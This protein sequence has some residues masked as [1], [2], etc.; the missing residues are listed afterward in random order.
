MLL[1]QEEINKVVL[2][3]ADVLSRKTS[4]KDRS[5]YPLIG[6]A[7]SITI[8]END[9]ENNSEIFANIKMDGTK[10]NALMIPAGGFRLKSS[11]ETAILE[12]DI[13]GHFRAKD[14]YVMKGDIVF[15]F[16]QTAIPPLIDDLINFSDIKKEDIDYYFF[17]QAN[18]F[19]LQKL[20]D[21][22]KVS[23]NKMP[24]N[25]VENFGNSSGASIPTA[26]A[27]NLDKKILTNKYKV[28]LC[29][30]GV[31][32]TW[33]SMLLDMGKLNICEMIDYK[34]EIE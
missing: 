25:V 17:H 28:C 16:V 15:N 3:N 27:F 8:I 5:I 6:D 30:Y 12:K 13:N 23:E 34:N 2:I 32:L 10:S 21:K 11:P 1:E 20:S 9:K 29:G 4:R 31:G 7:A 22:L 19:I 26:I 24:H 18:K 33:A 14:H